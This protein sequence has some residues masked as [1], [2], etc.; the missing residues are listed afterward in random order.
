MD[1]SFNE[2]VTQL[3]KNAKVMGEELIKCGYDLVT[4]G[5]ENHLILWDLHKQ[6]LTGS[7]VEKILEAS[8]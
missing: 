8:R 3:K 7:K 4:G 1:P 5:T 2:Y 6:G